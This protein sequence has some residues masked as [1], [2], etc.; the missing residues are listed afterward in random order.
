MFR[1]LTGHFDD[2]ALAIAVWMC[3]LP[4]V[5]LIVLP[6]VGWEISLLLA[7]AL[8]AVAVSICWGLCTWKIAKQ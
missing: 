4:A 7:A 8:L 6:L 2:M 3:V 1:R 5:G